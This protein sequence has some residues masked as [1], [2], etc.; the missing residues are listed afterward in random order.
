MTDQY[1]AQKESAG[2][3]PTIVFLLTTVVLLIGGP[4]IGAVFSLRGAAF[5]VGGMFLAALV[6]GIPSYLLQRAVSKIIARTVRNPFS[7]S[8][9]RA[10]KALGMALL[11]VQVVVTVLLT[12]LS[13]GYVI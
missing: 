1:S 13:F 5:I 6:V 11:F 8:V 2:G 12:Y 10:I 4:G 3:L 7:P 9:V